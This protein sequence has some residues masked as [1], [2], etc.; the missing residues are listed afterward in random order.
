M[1]TEQQLAAYLAGSM[2]GTERS[3]FEEQLAADESALQELTTQERMDT[4]LRF[5]SG[6][7]AD[8][9]I[10]QRAIMEVISGPSHEDVTDDLMDKLHRLPA[11]TTWLDWLR[12]R[13][14]AVAGPAIA[15]VLI[16]AWLLRTDDGEKKTG[17]QSIASVPPS[18][19]PL[20][21]AKGPRDPIKWPFAASS[22][23]N[24]PIGAGAQFVAVEPGGLD[25]TSGIFLKNSRYTH[26]LFIAREGDSQGQIFAK[27]L[28]A[29]IA[30]LRIPAAA[31]A[32][33]AH[34]MNIL[35]VAEDGTTLY[36]VA[37]AHREGENDLRGWNVI[38]TDLRGSG[39]PPELAS[40]NNAGLSPLAGSLYP[41]ELNTGIHRALGAIVP[42][43]VISLRTNGQAH[44]WPA[45]WSSGNQEFRARFAKTGNVHFGSLL[46]IPPE[47]DITKLG[48]GT[49]GPAFEIARAMQD[50]GVYV[51]DCFDP[52]WMTE[53]QRMGSP[54]FILCID[55]DPQRD[56]PSDLHE[57]LKLI[58]PHLKV[59]QNN[60]PT[61]VGGGGALRRP[62]APEFKEP[63]K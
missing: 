4:A 50:Y 12:E 33:A 9:Q 15:V 41:E 57:K 51:K 45:G 48:V 38:R 37:G 34:P 14:L 62:L 49:S 24:T 31:L 2:T 43:D 46:A 5:L 1:I 58:T 36:E 35:I 10:V 40:A 13:W 25:L 47:V 53:W 39:I 19:A 55:A 21:A 63:K 8:R 17:G 54:N 61:N 22:P 59:V 42:V 32:T 16:A 60:G 7:D 52:T 28:P 11:E 56:L 6:G 20:P 26:P 29:P 23:W 27:N 3:R 18:I 44:V 30:T